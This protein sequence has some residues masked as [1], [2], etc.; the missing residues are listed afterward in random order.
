MFFQTC[1]SWS[2]GEE[3]CAE[4]SDACSLQAAQLMLGGLHSAQNRIEQNSLQPT[5]YTLHWPKE[6][7]TTLERTGRRK[8]TGYDY[9]VK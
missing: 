2:A 1:W 5:V 9:I 6:I 4:N 8:K 7:L 3:G